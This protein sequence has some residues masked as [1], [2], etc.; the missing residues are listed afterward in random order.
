ME[1]VAKITKTFK[2]E[3]K[4][5]YPDREIHAFLDILLQ[6]YANMNK[7]EVFLNPEKKLF[8]ETV[9]ELKIALQKLKQEIPIQYIIGET[10]FYGLPVKLTS[11]VL[12]PRP[13]TEE[14]V[15]LIVKNHKKNQNINILDMGTGSG[16]IAVA[17]K[18]Y[19]PEAQV[20]A[21]DISEDA[22][23]IAKDNAA[24]NQTEIYFFKDDILNPQNKYDFFD[25]I[26]SNPPYVRE[27]EKELMKK[28]VLDNEPHLALFVKD[29]DALVFYRKIIDFA[30]EHLKPEGFI[31]FEINEALGKDAAELLNQ[32]V[33]KNIRIVK[34]IFGKERM[35]MAQFG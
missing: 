24:I 13:E 32:N 18:K 4:N 10:V 2:T 30:K 23:K 22:L 5:I 21:M 19:L 25:I 1:T 14:L 31:Y 26:V 27:S 8:P 29:D 9:F 16:C 7:T 28:N 11:D 6:Y 20:F 33:F 12:I 34:D 15:D 17:L 35:L 3:L